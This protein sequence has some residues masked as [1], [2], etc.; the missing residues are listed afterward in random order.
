M[1]V[2]DYIGRDGRRNHSDQRPRYPNLH[3]LGMLGF[4]LA[5]VAALRH[6]RDHMSCGCASTIGLKA[7]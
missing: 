4:T 7:R 2:P 3:I 6:V 1:V 5:Q